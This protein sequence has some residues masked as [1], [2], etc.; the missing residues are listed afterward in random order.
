[1]QNI[2]TLC[3]QNIGGTNRI[4]I[5]WLEM[6]KEKLFQNLENSYGICMEENDRVLE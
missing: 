6:D 5:I 4:I 2:N 3:E 1:M